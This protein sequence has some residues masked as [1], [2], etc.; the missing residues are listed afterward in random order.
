[1]HQQPSAS[2]TTRH[3]RAIRGGDSASHRFASA[4]SS[5]SSVGPQT[6]IAASALADARR[7]LVPH[8]RIVYRRETHEVTTQRIT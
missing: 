8:V 6:A 4:Q 1:V 2:S 7:L 3:A 5:Q